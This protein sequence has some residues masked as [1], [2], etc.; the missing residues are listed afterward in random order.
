MR[1]SA[2]VRSF[3][4]V[5]EDGKANVYIIA[6]D[7]GNLG[8]LNPHLDIREHSPSGFDW[9]Y[10]GSGPA[11]LAL[12]M[13]VTALGH[14]NG[15]SPDLYQEFKRKVVARFEESG[16]EYLMEDVRNFAHEFLKK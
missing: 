1:Q 5:R 12:A 11:Q 13:C 3:R 14:P 7:G 16:W 10:E 4:G 2:M 8:L 15:S 9:G 6:D